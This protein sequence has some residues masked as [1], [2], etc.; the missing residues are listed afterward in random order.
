ML[1]V[2][3]LLCP[4]EMPLPEVSLR[5]QTR[6]FAVRE[7]GQFVADL[8]GAGNEDLRVQR[9]EWLH[10]LHETGQARIRKAILFVLLM[11]SVV[12]LSFRFIKVQPR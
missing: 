7:G 10:Q 2:N 3:P 11:R 8:E 4:D 1:E 5:S 9:N 12:A 6:S